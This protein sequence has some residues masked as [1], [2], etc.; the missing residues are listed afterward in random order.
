MSDSAALDSGGLDSAALERRYRRLLAWFPA[1]HR[2]TYGEE[3]M[4]VLLASAPDGQHRPGPGDIVNLVSSG[5]RT[6]LRNW[7]GVEAVDSKWGDALAAFSVVA[8]IAM[9]WLLAD[10]FRSAWWDWAQVHVSPGGYGSQYRQMMA[11]DVIAVGVAG[12]V[13]VAL[14]VALAIYPALA[15][16]GH[17]APMAL[18][19]ITLALLGLVA[20]VYLNAR[21]S[22]DG[23]PPTGNTVFL[24]LESI[25]LIIAPQPG[26]GWRVLKVKGLITVVALAGLGFLADQLSLSGWIYPSPLLIRTAVAVVGLALALIF[27]SGA[28]KRLF[29]L[30]AIPAYPLLGFSYVAALLIPGGDRTTFLM[31]DYLPTLAIALL[32]VPPVWRGSRRLHDA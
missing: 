5:L 27:G 32:I 22:L 28:H 26:R 30:L 25:A 2:R 4:G 6:R 1:E 31:A 21:G 9:I 15:R 18:A 7:S 17:R 29:A 16:R 20:N 13:T 11:T 24:A 19:L 23:N 8:P 14:V 10:Q 12:V 3:M